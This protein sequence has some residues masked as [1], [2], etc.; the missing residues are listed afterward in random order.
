MQAFGVADQFTAEYL[1]KMAGTANL[2]DRSTGSGRSRGKQTS[3]STNVGSRETAWAPVTPD[4][5]RRLGAGEQVLVVRRSQPVR[6]RR[7]AFYTV[8]TP[9]YACSGP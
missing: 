9:P 3:R 2:F 8:A 7:V 6:A 4:E 5:L 1:S